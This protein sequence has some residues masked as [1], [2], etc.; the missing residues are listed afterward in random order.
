MM[1]NLTAWLGPL[2]NVWK[3]TYSRI[4]LETLNKLCFALECDT[5]DIFK[6]IPD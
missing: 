5:N 4:D 2:L 3:G 6:Y 1:Y